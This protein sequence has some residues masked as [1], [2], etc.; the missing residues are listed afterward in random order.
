MFSGFV[1]SVRGSS[2]E[3]EFGL[4]RSVSSVALSM[5]SKYL[6]QSWR[7]RGWLETPPKGIHCKLERRHVVAMHWLDLWQS[8]A[9][10]VLTGVADSDWESLEDL[11]LGPGEGGAWGGEGIGFPGPLL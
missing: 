10:G 1:Q 2:G 7:P 11:G 5:R 9:F 6:D 3:S 8:A 4:A